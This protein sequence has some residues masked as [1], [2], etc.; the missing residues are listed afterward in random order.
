MNMRE[1]SL[2]LF[3]IPNINYLLFLFFVP[4]KTIYKSKMRENK[5]NLWD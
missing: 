4:S 1:K 3:V 5:E 2:L